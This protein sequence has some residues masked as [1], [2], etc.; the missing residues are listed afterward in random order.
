[1]IQL[2]NLKELNEEN[3]YKLYDIVKPELARKEKLYSRYTRKGSDIELVGESGKDV[4]VPFEKY[5]V[6]IASGY[7]GGKEPTDEVQDTADEK[8]KNILKKL[9]NKITKQED[10]KES[11]EIMLNYITE[12]NDDGAENY[13]LVK[14]ILS[15]STCYE[16]LYENEDNEIVYSRVNPLQTQAIWDY[17]VPKN[18]IGVVQVYEEKDIN[19]TLRNVI[20]LTDEVGTRVFKG[21]QGGSN[22]YEEVT[23]EEPDNHNWGDVPFDV[24]EVPDGISLFEPV[25]SLIDAYQQLIENTKDTFQYN[26]DAKLKVTGYRPEQPLLVKDAKGNLIENE[27]RKKEDE[28][29]LNMKVFYTPDD[30]DIAW[31]EKSI[32]DSAIQNTLK[33]YIDLIMMSTGVPQTT[34]LGFT[35]ADN[36]SAIDRKFFSLE[37]TTTQAMQLLRMAYKRRWELVFNRLNIKGNQYDFRDITITL[38]KNLPA[39]ENEVVDMYMKLRGLISDETIIDRLPLNFDSKSEEAK[40]E[41]QEEA[42]LNKELEKTQAFNSVNEQQEVKVEKKEE[43]KEVKKESK[44]EDEEKDKKVHNDIVNKALNKMGL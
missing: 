31:I 19:G 6:D 28:T 11:M 4:V 35:K 26:N 3:I 30:G 22:S 21:G 39:N 29:L 7:L 34:D 33:T 2:S 8:K 44:E 18:L 16:I 42:Q 5:I 43:K 38:N 20:K 40:M 15:T 1:M 24:V 37:Q 12:Y 9:F 32:E 10:Y 23:E 17:S 36:A 25:L 27:N 14:D 41:E 13:Q